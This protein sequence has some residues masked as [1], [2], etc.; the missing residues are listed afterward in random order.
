M[1]TEMTKL[2]VPQIKLLARLPEFFTIEEDFRT[3]NTP[4]TVVR[5]EAGSELFRFGRGD[6]CAFKSLVRSGALVNL[7]RAEV[8]LPANGGSFVRITYGRAL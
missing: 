7:D 4:A 8:A 3:S 5:N 6:A 2:T 1:G